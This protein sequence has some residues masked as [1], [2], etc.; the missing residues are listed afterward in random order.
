MALN[1][2]FTSM[3]SVMGF[4]KTAEALP[5]QALQLLPSLRHQVQF[6]SDADN[7]LQK[8]YADQLHQHVV[9]LRSRLFDMYGSLLTPL[10]MK[11]NI[12]GDKRT[13]FLSKL[14]PSH[15]LVSMFKTIELRDSAI[16]TYTKQLHMA[17]E[18]S[19]RTFQDI[20]D[21][22]IAGGVQRAFL[23][24]FERSFGDNPIMTLLMC[25]IQEFET[26][27]RG[28]DPIELNFTAYVTHAQTNLIF[29]SET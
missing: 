20:D 13:L 24:D 5:F 2:S 18:F 9:S 28:E 23:F 7:E 27:M 21:W 15:I 16:A 8:L 17:C 22:I 3:K 10:Y 19:F 26:M 11:A 29:S 4:A 25:S 14:Q 12:H 1:T 6:V